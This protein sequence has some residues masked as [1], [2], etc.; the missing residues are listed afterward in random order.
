MKTVFITG[1]SKGIG[2]A[3]ALLFQNHG[4]N[5]AATMRRPSDDKDLM[6]LKN[7]K[8]YKLDVNDSTELSNCM[9]EV[10]K[11]FGS[12]NVLV[13]NAGIY[14]T[15]PL[16]SASE[17][18]INHLIGTNIVSALSVMKAFI[19]YFRTRKEG[20]IINISSVAGRAAFPYQ[21]IYT[22][23]KWAIEGISESLLYELKDL[24]IKIKV[25]EP[26]M[27]RTDLYDESKDLSLD[28]YPSEYTKSLKKWH[29][30]LMNSLKNG[31]T[32][33][34]TAKTIYKA[35]TDG[36]SKLRY[37]SG[38]DTKTAV[39]LRNLLPFPLYKK[40]VEMLTL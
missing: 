21:T 13:N 10:I 24:N 11:D 3:T 40:F 16:E 30:Y 28:Q 36:R 35:A 26:G 27:V 20:T 31:A 23:S 25:V 17:E 4:W 37:P 2:K 32:P 6:A 39:L 7:V 19:S 8:C 5:V 38:A 12:I 33:D 9:Q 34:I 29:H 14:L 15:K 18:D 1:A 22:A